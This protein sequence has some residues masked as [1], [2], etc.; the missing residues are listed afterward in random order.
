MPLS[1]RQGLCHWQELNAPH[2]QSSPDW[3]SQGLARDCRP[4]TRIFKSA[5]RPN[6]VIKTVMAKFAGLLILIGANTH[7]AR[8]QKI[9]I[10]ALIK[11][12]I[13]FFV[14]VHCFMTRS[15]VGRFQWCPC[16]RGRF[17]VHGTWSRLS[18]NLTDR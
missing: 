4:P 8:V 1:T 13:L 2:W 5:E 7:A 10:K 9:L 12:E 18:S 16:R 14:H 17:V 6:T 3:P 15:V 11:L